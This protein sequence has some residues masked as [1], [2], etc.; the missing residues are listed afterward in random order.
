MR[1]IGVRFQSY[2]ITTRCRYVIANEG[3]S[4]LLQH[5]PRTFRTRRYCR[6][7]NRAPATREFTIRFS[8]NTAALPEPMAQNV[9]LIQ[10]EQQPLIDTNFLK[11]QVS[12]QPHSET[13]ETSLLQVSYYLPASEPLDATEAVLT[14]FEQR[15]EK[16]TQYLKKFIPFSQNSL[17]RIYPLAGTTQESLF[18]HSTDD[19]VRFFRDAVRQTQFPPSLSY[20]GLIT[21]YQNLFV[22]GLNQLSWLGSSGYLQS[23][24][25][26]SELIWQRESKRKPV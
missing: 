2:Y 6:I 9:L 4:N 13:N 15:H 14:Q 5:F 7:M 16:I 12:P 26:T 25:K 22:L 20:P 17:N 23:A 8:I 19:Y 11:L 18:E 3:F 1:I 24:L 21:P 10:D